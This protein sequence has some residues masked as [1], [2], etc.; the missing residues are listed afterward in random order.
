MA[1]PTQ[2]QPD[3]PSPDPDLDLYEINTHPFV[4]KIWLEQ[5]ADDTGQ[6]IWRGHIT[7]VP[8][9]TRRYIQSLR[10]IVEFI[11][12]YLHQMGVVVDWPQD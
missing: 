5:A 7:H 8:S 11:R 9:R 2:S 4:I 3:Q 1:E 6:A 10:E 12:P